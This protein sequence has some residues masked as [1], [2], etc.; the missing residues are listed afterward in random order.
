MVLKDIYLLP[1]GDEILDLPDDES[2]EMN[3][4]IKSAVRRDES[5]VL[6]IASPHG[7][8]LTKNIAVVN[9][10]NFEGDFKIETMSLHRKLMNE[11][12]LTESILRNASDETEELGFVTGSGDKSIFP[13]DFGTLIPLEFFPDRPLV[14]LGQS[15]LTDRKKLR[16]FGA[17]LYR[18]LEE[19][20]KSVS[21]IISADQAHTHSSKGP[22][23]YSGEAK[24]YEA[25]VL[26]CIRSNDYSPLME[27]TEE[28]IN[29]AKPDSYWNLVILS[30]I[31]EK[32]N[33]KLVLDYHYVE[34]YYGMICAHSYA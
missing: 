25:V 11:R 32:S 21:L 27:V 10:E 19:Y 30:S 29:N 4:A 23:G 16:S 28:T 20:D 24:E 6:V 13:M 26:D 9:T 31:L 1:H 17:K 2:A 3:K 34:I 22:Y 14:Y 8:K 12:K 15:R 18:A 5:D 7:V 33:R